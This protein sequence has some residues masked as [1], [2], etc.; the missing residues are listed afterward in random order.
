VVKLRTAAL[1]DAAEL[2]RSAMTIFNSIGAKAEA[3]DTKV[4][5]VE[6]LLFHG[7][8]DEALALVET[9]VAEHEATGEHEPQLPA[10]LRWRG[11]AIGQL[12]DLDAGAAEVHRALRAARRLGAI[13]EVGLALEALDQ[14]NVATGRVTLEAEN[15][16]RDDIIGRLRLQPRPAPPGWPGAVSGT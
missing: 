16:E 9:L 6:C 4:S 15:S 10:M 14:F 2:L 8:A 12:G 7:R 13:H 11:Y 5:I 1:D 3:F